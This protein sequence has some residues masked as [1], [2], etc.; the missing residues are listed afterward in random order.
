MAD[1]PQSRYDDA[2]VDE[3]ES[4][5]GAVEHAPAST[6]ER[7]GEH[8]G[9]KILSSS[10]R[11]GEAT[12]TVEPKALAEVM[13]WLR[14]EGGF[15]LLSD[16][17][18]HDCHGTEP[19]FWVIYQLTNVVAAERLRVKVGL[20]EKKPVVGSVTPLWAGA[21]FLE[22]EVYDLFGVE[23]TDH[24]NLKRIMMPEEWEGYPLRK[25]YP[26]IREEVQFSHNRRA[27]D[28]RKPYARK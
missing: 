11:L 18:A 24:P 27:V 7:L 25:D 14:D 16:L 21:N 19:R 10:T 9:D 23:F 15:A 3:G 8:F 28:E 26:L 20:P 1:N 22:R 4:V 6:L 2:L 17:T 12:A 13:Q 5:G